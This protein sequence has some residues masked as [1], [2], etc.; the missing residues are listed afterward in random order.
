MKAKTYTEPDEIIRVPV[1]L[2]NQ[3]AKDFHTTSQT[4]YNALQYK[5]KSYLANHI[6][7]AA[8]E[9]EGTAY[10]RREL[11]TESSDN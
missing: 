1:E 3:L 10:V 5:H 6:R 4:V 7:A 11:I 2:R 8:L 9:R